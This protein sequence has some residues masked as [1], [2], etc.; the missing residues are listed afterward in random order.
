MLLE[1]ML[2]LI[3]R[4]APG[5]LA[6]EW[7]NSGLLVGDEKAAVERVLVALELDEAVVGEALAGGFD[8]IITHHPL[9]FTPIKSLVESNHKERLL[10]KLVAGDIALVACHTNVDASSGGLAD[11]AAEALGLQKTEPLV[12]ASAGWHKLVAYIPVDATEAVAE[13]V[14]A[15][16]GG[17]V[18]NYSGCAFRVEGQ[19]LFTPGEGSRPV[20]GKVGLS[21]RTREDR[22]ETVVPRHRL[23]EVVRAFVAAH[24]YEEPAFDLYAV[25]DVLPGVGIG[26]VGALTEEC[27]VRSLAQK[28]LE[29]FGASRVVWSGDGE[30][31]VQR[32]AVLPGSGRGS[33]REA[34]GRC[35]ALI[36]GD[37][38]HH[39][40]EE[41][42]DVD[43]ALVDVPHGE[44]EWWAFRRWSETLDK[45]LAG[46]GVLLSA[47]KKW[48]SP[49]NVIV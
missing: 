32:A 7:D 21:E 18:G 3:E 11:I 46:Q 25:E 16:G 49:W 33:I 37:L 17:G 48:V 20:V 42:E 39:D 15:A 23:G 12:P 30:R 1:E 6:Q 44:I 27:S 47:S 29:Q 24:P 9:L 19:G 4:L 35:E 34:A 14:F 43:L 31:T 28:A 38:S 26:R 13:A 40:A 36:T 10:R 45:E 8:T 2:G 5:G 41:A 22:W